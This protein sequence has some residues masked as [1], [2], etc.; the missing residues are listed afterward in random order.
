MD[1]R[2]VFEGI[3][4]VLRTGARWRDLPED[5]GLS[6]ATCWRRLNRWEAD[7]VWEGVG[8]EYLRRLD[9]RGLLAWQECFIDATYMPARRGAPPSGR[10][11][12]G[13]VRS[14][15]RWQAARVYQS[16]FSRRLRTL[17]SRLSP[18][19]R[20]AV[21]GYLARDEVV[22]A[23]NLLGSSATGRT[24]AVRS[25]NVSGNGALTSLRRTSPAERRPRTVASSAAIGASGSS[26]ARTAGGTPRAGGP[27]PGGTGV[28]LPSWAS[29]LWR[30]S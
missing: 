5:Y 25:G 18:S 23:R 28:S 30:Y 21:F 9:D 10:P 1:S 19:G 15:W 22:P 8:Q 11:G 12:R 24:T 16:R 4:R 13:T 7:G 26:S 29:S 20:S 17:T 6:P 2:A 14:A 3:L 27:P